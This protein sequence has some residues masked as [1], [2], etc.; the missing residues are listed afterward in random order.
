VTATSNGTTFEGKLQL[1]DNQ[2][3]AKSGTVRVR[4]VFDNPNGAL[5]AGQFARL[6]MGQPKAE[7][8]LMVS[9]R[10]VGTDQNKKFVMVVG[11]DNKAVYRE[12][13]LGPTAEGLRIVT[14]GLNA[15]ER[16]IVNGLQRVRPGAVVA[17][18]L[19]P[20]L[21]EQTAKRSGG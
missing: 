9:E 5:M 4:A 2:V 20:M 15:G 12:V 7:P 14:Q 18:K 16:V 19:V 6:R 8:A 21:A 17:P 11:D 10:A 1:I 3:D 13:T